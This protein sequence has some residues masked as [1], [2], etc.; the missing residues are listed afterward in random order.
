MT[1]VRHAPLW[2]VV[3]CAGLLSACSGGANVV[4]TS[5]STV[6]AT[7]TVT[8]TITAPPSPTTVAPAVGPSWVVAP[9]RCGAV[10]FGADGNV[11]PA[12]YPDGRPNLAADVYL[13]AQHLRVMSLGTDASPDQVLHAMCLDMARS[14]IPIETTAYDVAQA[15]QRW[16][17]GV[18]PADELLNGCASRPS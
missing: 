6:T 12:T 3:G 4:A 10:A 1:I 9:E 18:C 14:T 13:R 7:A 17:F 11:S 15:E 16:S 2:L 8:E 5:T